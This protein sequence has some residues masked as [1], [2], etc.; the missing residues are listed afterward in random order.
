MKFE[1]Q[2]RYCMGVAMK[3]TVCNETNEE[4]EAVGIRLP[5]FNYTNREVLSISK[6]EKKEEEEIKRVKTLTGGEKSG[7]IISN[8][9]DSSLYEYDPVHALKGVGPA[10]VRKLLNI[11]IKIVKNLMFE[12]LSPI[13]VNSSLKELSERPDSL[14]FSS[15]KKLHI[16][17]RTATLG[18]QPQETN[19]LLAANPYLSRYGEQNWRKEISRVSSMKKYCCIRELVGHLHDKTRDAFKG[20]RYEQS[21]LFTTTLSSL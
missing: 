10:T 19:H 1:K 2:G 17:S 12:S 21:Y 20:T 9:P 11:G 3:K 15:L 16:Q 7:W 6:F 18:A 8:R 13:E 14:T 5:L 4:N